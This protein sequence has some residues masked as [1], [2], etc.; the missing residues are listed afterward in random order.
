MSTSGGPP[1][2]ERPATGSAAPSNDPARV[3]PP[4][5]REEPDS[6]PPDGAG[7]DAAA[8]APQVRK[9][10]VG[11]LIAPVMGTIMV[12]T[13]VWANH[14]VVARDLPWGV[15]GP[16]PLTSAVQ[17]NVNM[18]I[19]TYANQADLETA[20]GE[21]T[22]YGGF[23][24]QTNT[25]V[26]SEAAS[27]WAPGVMPAEYLKAGQA[28]GQQVHF[29]VINTLPKEDPE[30]VV[31][32]LVVFVLLVAGYLGSTMAMQRTGHAAAH[33]RVAILAGY[34]VV[35]SL[36]FNLIVGPGLHAYPDVGRNFWP[37]WGEFA[38]VLL[39]VAMLAGSLQ[40][41]IGPL[42]TLVTVVLVVFL[43]NPSTGG[44]NGTA[45]LP[46]FWQFLG[47]ILPPWNGVTLVRNTLY[48]H[49]NA[50][51]QQLIVLSLYVVVGAIL[52]TILGWGRLRWWRGP[53]NTIDRAE[54]T[55]IAAVPPG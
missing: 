47:P 41:L 44:V 33:R 42:G 10:L 23:N 20:A 8:R 14:G 6:P 54:E 26:I 31:P 50:I 30:G 12:T 5:P 40:S 38:L 1:D 53:Q 7:T 55:G 13:Y 3:A 11:L 36:V 34:A 45:Y 32:G 35:A 37:L 51:T 24:A 29:S 21:T 27:L 43:G 28:L 46:A 39:A 15:T 49:G 22:I 48:F 2:A 9:V 25:V 4:N 18:D 16:S 17:Q 19:H 52:M